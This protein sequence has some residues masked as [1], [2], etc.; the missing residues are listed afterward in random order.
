MSFPSV[1][2]DGC[3]H[4]CPGAEHEHPHISAGWLLRHSV[5]S[6]AVAGL[7]ATS[8]GTQRCLSLSVTHS[9]TRGV[10]GAGCLPPCASKSPHG[11]MWGRVK[12]SRSGCRTVA[13]AC[14][15]LPACRQGHF[16]LDATVTSGDR[17]TSRAERGDGAAGWDGAAPAVGHRPIRYGGSRRGAGGRGG[18]WCEG[19]PFSR[20]PPPLCMRVSGKRLWGGLWSALTPAALPTTCPGNS[21]PGTAAAPPP[22]PLAGRSGQRWP[23][24]PPGGWV[25]CGGIGVPLA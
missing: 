12:R 24:A 19:P 14:C 8:L 25:A 1:L 6:P 7:N 10:L 5:T 23:P 15:P 20:P 2:G 3:D 13:A 21:S 11:G 22:R 9:Q 4:R 17:E 18:L 16:V